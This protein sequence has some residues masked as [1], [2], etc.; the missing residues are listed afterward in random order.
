MKDVTEVSGGKHK[1]CFGRTAMC[2][3]HRGDGVNEVFASH[4]WAPS[5]CGAG[6]AVALRES[7]FY[8]V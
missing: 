5:V 6:K 4:S 1:W 2:V 7:R 3:S 8:V